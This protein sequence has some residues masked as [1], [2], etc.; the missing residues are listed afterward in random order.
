MRDS[1][2]ATIEACA[3]GVVCPRKRIANVVGASGNTRVR[4]AEQVDVTCQTGVAGRAVRPPGQLL[5]VGKLDGLVGRRAVACG[6]HFGL[7]AQQRTVGRVGVGHASVVQ[8]VGGE[9]RIHPVAHLGPGRGGLHTI[10]RRAIGGG[11]VERDKHR[12]AVVLQRARGLVARSMAPR[13]HVRKVGFG[14]IAAR[15][16][17]RKAVQLVRRA[18]TLHRLGGDALHA[19]VRVGDVGA[20]GNGRSGACRRGS[21]LVVE[22]VVAVVVSHVGTH[23]GRLAGLDGSHVVA[24]REPAGSERLNAAGLAVRIGGRD[25]TGV[26]TVVERGVAIADD[27]AHLRCSCDAARVG[28]VHNAKVVVAGDA[29]HLRCAV[30]IT[31]VGASDDVA[32]GVARNA[33]DV[34]A[35]A[36]DLSCVGTGGDVF[37]DRARD[38]ADVSTLARDLR[39]V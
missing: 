35:L 36:C 14:S 27:A 33:A 28:A 6:G 10:P 13:G 21:V 30:D 38:A 15:V 4:G 17:N 1:A 25:G 34:L 32:A 26:E 2:L 11:R 22:A 9:E 7:V 31:R 5:G 29:A 23:R 39:R 24:V 37:D 20:A 12:V 19:A 16:G 3:R 18:P 8:L